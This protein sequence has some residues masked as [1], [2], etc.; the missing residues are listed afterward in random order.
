[1]ETTVTTVGILLPLLTFVGLIVGFGLIHAARNRRF[2]AAIVG[3]IGAAMFFAVASMALYQLRSRPLPVPVAPV[4]VPDAAYRYP[5]APPVPPPMIVLSDDGERRPAEAPLPDDLENAPLSSETI[6]DQKPQPTAANSGPRPAWMDA[7]TARLGGAYRT[8]VAWADAPTGLV[9]GVYRTRLAVGDYATREECD[10]NLPEALRQAVKAY[11]ER[12]IG[13]G[14]GQLTNVPLPYI[15]EHIVKEE[16]EEH[17]EAS[18]GPM[19][20]LHVLMEFDQNDRD[21]IKDMH[22]QA[23]VAERLKYTAVATGGLFG[24]LA[25]VFGYLKLDT[26][27]RGYYSGRLRMAAAL[28]ILALVAGLLVVG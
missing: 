14:A 9:G 17:P 7:P 20:R 13:E 15:H 4:A 12:L 22:Q 25:T 21:Y 24:L 10:R 18:F 19:V 27:T 11:A 23:L 8:R 16:W 5:P 28:M 26:L 1:V 3:A 2:G 6:D